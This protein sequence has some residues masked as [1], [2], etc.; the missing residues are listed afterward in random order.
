MIQDCLRHNVNFDRTNWDELL[1]PNEYVLNSAKQ[2]ST[3]YSPFELDYGRKVLY[4]TDLMIHEMNKKDVKFDDKEVIKMMDKHKSM[5]RDAIDCLNH[6]RMNQE[7]Y[8]TVN[9]RD[10]KFKVGDKVMLRTK[11]YLTGEKRFRP[12][13][14]LTA[15]WAGPF[16]IIQKINE[17]AFRLKLPPKWSIHDVF[18]VANFWPA[19]ITDEFSLREE[20]QPPP[21]II[22]GF[23]EY[24]V[25][26]IL[27]KRI[28]AKTRK[29]E[30]L[31]LWKGHPDEV[32]WEKEEN[33]TH[34]QELLDE[35]NAKEFSNNESK[36]DNK[37]EFKV[38]SKKDAKIY[39]ERT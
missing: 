29:I 30:Y 18:H 13:K 6:A 10:Y 33:M 12:K 31:V 25:E 39:D 34:C 22:D 38:K 5:I 11:N 17:T 36:I 7:I 2:T 26:S 15:K 35:V 14:K 32:S 9:R 8:V 20:L 4:P 24:E 1:A 3:S 16:E 23:E 21:D 37:Y 19:Q 28:N 27:K